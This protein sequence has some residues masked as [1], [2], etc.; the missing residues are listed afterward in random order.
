[1]RF[2]SFLLGK[3]YKKESYIKLV[4]YFLVFNIVVTGILTALLYSFSYNRL[5]SEILES[6]KN[7]LSQLKGGTDVILRQI[8]EFLIQITMDTTVANF[9]EFRQKGD[10]ETQL[11]ITNRLYNFIISNN[12]VD[13]IRVYFYKQDKI[14]AVESGIVSMEDFED[15]E[16]IS[17]I[18]SRNVTNGWVPVRKVYS[19]EKNVNKDVISVVKPIP[20]VS[21]APEAAI[22]VNIKDQYIKNLIRSIGSVKTGSIFIVN[23]KG[24]IL[25]QVN[26]NGGDENPAARDFLYEAL[27]KGQGQYSHEANGKKNLISHIQSDMYEWRYINIYPYS[28]IT[29]KIAFIQRYFAVIFSTNSLLGILLSLFF[30]GKIN[31]PILSIANML[32][33]NGSYFQGGNIY[34]S[35]EKNI[36]KLIESKDELQNTIEKN[37]PILINNFI[38]SLLYGSAGSRMEILDTLGYYNID[39]NRSTYFSVC[40][41]TIDGYSDYR[42]KYSQNQKNM[43]DIYLKA[44]LQDEA[45][46]N[47]TV[48]A[49]NNHLNQLVAIVNFDADGYEKDINDK[50][51]E[52]A[53]G[54]HRSITENMSFTVSAGVGN[55]CNDISLIHQSYDEAVECLQY[56]VILGNNKVIQYRDLDKFKKNRSG[57]PFKLGQELLTSLS[58]GNMDAV[59][60]KLNEIFAYAVEDKGM[61]YEYNSYIL[62]QLLCSTLTYIYETGMDVEKIF[63]NRNVFEDILILNTVEE[64]YQWF[65]GIYDRVVKHMASKREH[66]NRDIVDALQVYIKE[67]YVQELTLTALGER[68]YLSGQYLSRVFKEI[69][70][71]PLKRYI[72]DCRIE[73]AKEFLKNPDYSIEAVS[74]KVGYDNV[75]SFMKTFKKFV[76]MSPGDY[77][78]QLAGSN[79]IRQM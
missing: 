13:S 15:R 44:R 1:M 71:Q 30:V 65:K 20:L 5:E 14:L 66:A 78:R 26:G 45:D 21:A 34:S 53:M 12:Y 32:N 61:P 70:G 35:I 6:N 59:E 77:R 67:N 79:N 27:R 23:D 54:L 31:K 9:L 2:L 39:I 48:L 52:I 8:D 75:R 4:G 58:Q 56:T 7:M 40:A 47:I 49:V 51:R 37:Q 60:A 46:R 19:K 16:L 42:E 63:R 43:L 68:F 17:L 25:S 64:R 36:Y 50:N 18:K 41:F 69:T 24:D 11:K 55:V 33:M 74:K 72:S 22:I 10:Y 62:I 3:M 73:K 38:Q 76:G 28:A 57:Y 29:D